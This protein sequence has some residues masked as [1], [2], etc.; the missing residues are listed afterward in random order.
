M[1]STS[2]KATGLANDA[3]GNIKQAAGKVAG[4]D[5]LQAQGKQESKGAGQKAAGD[6]KA[7]I[8]YAANKAADAI[9]KKL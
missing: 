8:Q 3:I 4:S 2:D 6:A 9:N 7:A 5:K 1:G